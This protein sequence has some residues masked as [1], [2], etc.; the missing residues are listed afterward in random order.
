MS[1][2]QVRSGRS[3][4]LE[5]G[6]HICIGG[7]DLKLKAWDI[8]EGFAQPYFVNKRFEAGVTTIQSH[9]Y[10]EHLIAV[11]RWVAVAFVSFPDSPYSCH[12]SAMTTQSDS[13]T[14][15][16]HQ[17]LLHRLTSA[18][19]SGVSNGIHFRIA[20]MTSWSLA[21]T[22]DSRPSDSIF[23]L[24]RRNFQEEIRREY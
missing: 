7:D 5:C 17:F 1:F 13:L 8:R 14:R 24:R 4:V 10:I 18:E 16:N 15:A 21:C 23:L 19:A 3:N 6:R 20:N 12:H 11:G 22:T 9:P 2:I